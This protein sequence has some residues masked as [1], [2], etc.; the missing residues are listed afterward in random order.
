LHIL[1]KD[2]RVVRFEPNW[3][4]RRYIA[5]VERQ[6]SVGKPVRIIVLKARQLG[7]STATEALMFTQSFVQERMAGLVVAHE[8]EGAKHLLGMHE[9]FWEKYPFKAL[10][11]RQYQSKIEKSWQETASHIRVATAKNAT[12]GRS[13]TLHFLH[14]SE[15]GFWLAAQEVMLG[16][17]QT[18]PIN[19]Y[20]FVVIESTANGVGNAFYN[21]WQQAVAGESDYTPLFFPWHQHPEYLAS[22]VGL[23]YANLGHLDSE[24]KALRSMGLSDDRLAWRRY[25]VRNLARGDLNKFHQEYPSSAEEAFIASGTNIFPH[26]KLQENYEPMDGIKGR[27]TRERQSVRFQPD[28]DGPLTIFRYP[29]KDRSWG[30]YF[31][32]GD[33]TRT[34]KGDPACAQVFN[35]RTLEQV[36]VWH[37]HIDPSTFGEI[38]AELGRYY[39]DAIV[40]TEITGP[41]FATIGRLQG[42]NY[43]YIWKHARPDYEP[44]VT[45]PNYGWNTTEQTKNAAIGWLLKVLVDGDL[46]VHHKLT[47]YEMRDYVTLDGGGMGPASDEG[48]DDTVTSL[49]IG[50]ACHFMEVPTEAYVGHA[51]NN[52]LEDMPHWMTW[53]EQE[54]AL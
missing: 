15:Y 13:Q 43:P 35:R 31:V 29:S 41:G 39:N 26:T 16:L 10:W 49:A 36:A 50:I 52:P 17:L 40:T 53:G 2:L 28:I 34:L 5:E 32:S 18:V 45:Q 24:E 37:G 33:P 46:T 44:G 6:Q 4:Q 48:H 9:L 22:A 19:P 23:P 8:M 27:L 14:C 51:P 30:V 7:I 11:T 20:T 21:E 42:I 12:A 1:T 54:N 25:A 47:F 3:A 38:L